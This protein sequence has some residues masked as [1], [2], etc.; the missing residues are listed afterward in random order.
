MKYRMCVFS[1]YLDPLREE[2]LI[3]LTDDPKPSEVYDALRIAYNQG[4]SGILNNTRMIAPITEEDN[5]DI[6]HEV[7]RNS[8]LQFVVRWINR[9]ITLCIGI[10]TYRTL[11]VRMR[12]ATNML[13]KLVEDE[14]L[15]KRMAIKIHSYLCENVDNEIKLLTNEDLPF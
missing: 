11:G 8:H 5:Y 12:I 13:N 14:Y 6:V 3:A 2:N 1:N 9:K 15:S 10:E 7:W 4:A